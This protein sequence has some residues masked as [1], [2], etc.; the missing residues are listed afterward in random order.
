[1]PQLPMRPGETAI[2]RNA[3]G[4]WFFELVGPRGEIMLFSKAYDADERPAALNAALSVEENGVD[5]NKYIVSEDN[6]GKYRFDLLGGNNH[7][8]ASSQL[9]ASKLEAEEG[10]QVT[11]DLI[12]DILHFKAAVERGARFELTRNQ[13]DKKWYFKLLAKDGKSVL[14]E[15]QGYANRTDAVNGME[16]VRVNGKIARRYVLLPEAD[17]AYVVLKAGNGW[18]IARSKS[19]D[20]LDEVQAALK[21]V[22]ALLTSEHVGSPW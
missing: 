11:R 22:Q 6:Q 2:T 17:P 4:E 16:S 10:A 8:I 18:E 13:S 3:Q 9:Y 21:S 7:V 12:A 5:L 15:S 14:L 20:S 19:Y 1:M